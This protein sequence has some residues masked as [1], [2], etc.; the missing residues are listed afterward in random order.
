TD[1]PSNDVVTLETT[2]EV[3]HRMN[4]LVRA[5][6]LALGF[7][8]SMAARAQDSIPPGL[9]DWQ[10]WVLH[11]QEFRRCPFAASA[12]AEAGKPIDATEFRC[13]W[14]ERLTLAVESGGGTFSQRWQVY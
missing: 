13:I 6:I 8:C 4:T 3:G 2:T 10:G 7:F 12:D 5:G 1:L 9:R 11:E 14:P